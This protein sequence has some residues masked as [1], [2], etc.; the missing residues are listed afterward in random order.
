[1]PVIIFKLDDFTVPTETWESVMEYGIKHNIK[2]S[3]GI[4]GKY[5]NRG[6][7]NTFDW[8][9]RF[10]NTGNFEFWNHGYT[11]EKNINGFEFF[12]TP[13]EEQYLSLEKTQ[14][15]GKEKLGITFSTFGAPFNKI[16][17][18]TIL[19]LGKIPEIKIWLKGYLKCNNKICL[20][21][22]RISCEF[23]K[24][25]NKFFVEFERFKFKY[26]TV[27]ASEYLILEFHPAGWKQ[28]NAIREFFS[29]VDYLSHEPNVEFMLPSQ[30]VENSDI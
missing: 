7:Q 9:K 29:I 18:N 12:G 25:N 8:I 30:Y 10:N 14:R 15:L 27:K 13:L 28:T 26:N 3:I 21:S 22:S 24:D 1:M 23:F 5:L 16:D 4:I 6:E 17:E 11:H 2:F 19:A 20:H